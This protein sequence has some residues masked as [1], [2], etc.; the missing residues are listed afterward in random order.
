M[1]HEGIEAPATGTP[2]GRKVYAASVLIGMVVVFAIVGAAKWKSVLM[3][4]TLEV[5]GKKIV[6]YDEVL[7]LANVTTQHALYDINLATLQ[8]A[9][10]SNAFIR[11]AKVQREAPSSIHITISEREPAAMLV[12]SGR[13]EHLYLDEEGFLLPGVE[14][15]AIYDLPVIT[16]LDSAQSFRPGMR[17]TNPDIISA[18]E[19][20]KA[21]RTVGPEVSHLISEVRVGNG[22]DIVL[23]AF[24]AGTPIIFGQGGAL[25]KLATL[26]AFW[27]KFIVD[28]SAH[29]LEY[30]DLR[31]EGQVITLPKSSAL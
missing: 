22:H 16:G 1:T 13:S 18:L 24:D 25:K 8:A 19:I 26:D 4:R 28:G 11:H 9:L 14:S 23:Y 29:E 3:L 10:Q 12:L 21:A 17:T 30:I 7:R 31:F 2:Y 15:P 5:E 20:L 27:K 6:T